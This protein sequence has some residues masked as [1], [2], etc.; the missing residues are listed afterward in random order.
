M[1][2]TFWT[3]GSVAGLAVA[4]GTPGAL[5]QL[6]AQ[7][8]TLIRETAQS[9]CKSVEAAIGKKTDLEIQGDIR[10][11][12]SGL[13]QKFS[14]AGGS[15]TGKL[16]QEDFEGISREATATAIENDRNCRER[17]F[18]KMFDRLM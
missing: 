6:N 16:T 15:V 13:L 17:V 12:L 18:N 11:Q 9:V 4:M 14:N 5:A 2:T 3:L 10:A 7:Q 1:R 8:I